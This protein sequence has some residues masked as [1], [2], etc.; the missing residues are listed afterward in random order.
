MKKYISILLLSISFIVFA[1]NGEV[2]EYY[3]TG[4]LKSVSNYVNDVEHGS[5]IAYYKNGNVGEKLTMKNGEFH[6]LYI[7]YYENGNKEEESYFK[8][9]LYHGMSKDYYKNGNIKI[10]ATYINDYENGPFKKYWETGE[11]K[12]SGTNITVYKDGEYDDTLKTGV[13]KTYLPSGELVI[14]GSYAIDEYNNEIEIGPWIKKDYYKSDNLYN[15]QIKE[16]YRLLNCEYHGLCKDYYENGQI[17]T[18]GEYRNDKEEGIHKEYYENGQLKT[19]GEY[20]NGEEEGIHKE[21]SDNGNLKELI[22]YVNGDYNGWY[23]EY[24]DEG[25][26]R[27]KGNVEPSSGYSRYIKGEP[28]TEWEY[29]SNDQL[30]EKTTYNYDMEKHGPYEKYH[31][32]GDLKE[33]GQY[34][35]DELDGEWYLNYTDT[36]KRFKQLYENGVAVKSKN[37]NSQYDS[38]EDEYY[39]INVKNKCYKEIEIAIRIKNL[40]GEWESKGWYTIKPYDEAYVAN[41][42]NRIFY[43]YAESLDGKLKWKG[44]EYKTVRGEQFGFKKKTIPESHGYGE[45][46]INLTCGD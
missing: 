3:D 5:F 37:V 4:E 29:F 26:P 45:Y 21:Y 36:N 19:I 6:G 30:E 18:T 11:L 12:E 16:D 7:S 25:K 44:D 32:N 46:Y 38:I 1:Q 24:W 22:T 9:D 23:E 41:T 10:E 15:L 33:K 17:E 31:K 20:K 43:Y 27:Y 42:N 34:K 13:Y 2:K 40:D 35:N 28:W 8:N 39:K 14:T